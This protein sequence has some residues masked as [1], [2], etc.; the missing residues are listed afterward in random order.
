M[1]TIVV[2]ITGASGS[3]YA[4]RLLE[5]LLVAGLDVHL[6]ISRNAVS[7]F[8]QELG[9][10]IDIDNFNISQIMPDSDD[11][12]ADSKLMSL[13]SDIPSAYA[14]SSIFS[15]SDITRERLTYHHYLDFYSG[16]ASG[17]FL[18]DGM[19]ICPC[20]TGTM[21]S[22]ANGLSSNLIHRAA[23]VHLKERRKLIVVPR[24]TPVSTLQLANLHQLSANGAVILPASPGF[25]HGP[26][27]IHD[28]IDFVVGRICD[29]LHINHNLSERWGK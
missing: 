4:V 6:T 12:P 14:M 11:I 8:K 7:V 17:S 27:T 21:A 29:Q 1:K 18:T 13:R 5:A 24:E 16:I 3:I 22:I 19:I 2:A 26:L 20:S 28:L 25:Y 15:E 9:L 23:D 10:T